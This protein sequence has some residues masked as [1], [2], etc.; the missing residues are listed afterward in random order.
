MLQKTKVFFAKS[1]IQW[2]PGQVGD[3]QHIENHPTG[4]RENPACS[5]CW[6]E[7]CGW[8]AGGQL[9]ES[10]YHPALTLNHTLWKAG[11]FSKA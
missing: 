1:S 9:P 5:E 3:K 11:H 7:L 8:R 6:H 2:L 4:A 10:G